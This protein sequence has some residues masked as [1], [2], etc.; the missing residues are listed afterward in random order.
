MRPSAITCTR[1]S[2]YAEKQLLGYIIDGI[3]N[4]ALRN[5]ARIS[6]VSTKEELRAR[7]QAGGTVGQER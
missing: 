1:R 3:P 2:S 6:G 7:V 5:K 4:R